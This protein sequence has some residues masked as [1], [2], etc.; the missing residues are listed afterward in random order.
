LTQVKHASDQRGGH[1][2]CIC[3]RNIASAIA[4]TNW[5]A[6][7]VERRAACGL[8]MAFL[9]GRRYRVHEDCPFPAAA[10]MSEQLQLT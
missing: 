5:S 3:R 4:C 10:N 7:E 8:F 6:R 2:A 9:E 1:F